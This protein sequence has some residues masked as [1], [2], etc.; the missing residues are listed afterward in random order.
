M[1]FVPC[2]LHSP[3]MLLLHP[4]NLI[5]GEE[6]RNCSHSDVCEAV[7]RPSIPMLLYFADILLRPMSLQLLSSP[8]AACCWMET[9]V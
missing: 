7:E 3:L 4:V 2:A 8:N 1:S 6:Y 5:F 9:C